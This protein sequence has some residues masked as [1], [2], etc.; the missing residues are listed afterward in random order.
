MGRHVQR[1][2]ENVTWH[3]LHV[4]PKI[5]Y[6]YVQVHGHFGFEKQDLWF[7]QRILI[8]LSQ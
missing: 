7:L 2:N 1:I 3:E 6:M 4:C 8:F 5:L